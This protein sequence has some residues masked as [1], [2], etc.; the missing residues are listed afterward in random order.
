MRKVFLNRLSCLSYFLI[1]F[2]V[3]CL[4]AYSI[5][6]QEQITLSELFQET[7]ENV[8]LEKVSGEQFL[9][10]TEN[11]K[12]TGYA[13]STRA[14]TGSVG[15]SGKPLDIYVA[16]GLD[17]MIK[18]AK[19]IS[20]NEPIL[21]IGVSDRDLQNLVNNII[22][23]NVK[24]GTKET[25]KANRLEVDHITGATI[26][27]LVIKDSILRSAR[28]VARKTGI[29]GEKGQ[30]RIDR[31]TYQVKTWEELISSNLVQNRKILRS[32]LAQKVQETSE[33]GS[34]LIN[35]LHLALLTSPM[36]GQNLLGQQQ[37]ERLMA[38]TPI[39]DSLIFI[40][41]NGAYSFKG[42]A[43]RRSGT[44]DRIE[45]IQGSRTI[46]LKKEHYQNL[47]KLALK[48]APEF[49]EAGIFR[50]PEASGFNPVKPWS[51]NFLIPHDKANGETVRLAMKIN[52]VLPDQMI[53]STKS[54]TAP[55]KE[56][57]LWED[58]WAERNQEIAILVTMFLVLVCI[59]L[60]QDELAK[61]VKLYRITRLTFLLIT[62]VFLGLYAG[63]QLSVVNLI[64]FSQSLL[65]NFKWENF[66]LDP[67]I[68]MLWSFVA[69][70][71]LFWGRGVF[72]GWLCPFGALQELINAGAKR[73]GIKQ[74]KVPWSLHERLWPIKYIA[75][76]LIL[77]ISLKSVNEAYQYAEIE[78]FKTVI[79]LKF[80][81]EWQ[82][83]LYALILLVMGLF[84]ERFYC[85]YLCPLGAA[86]AIPAKLRLFEWLNR[87]PQCGRECRLCEDKCTVQ[88]INPIGQINPNECIYCLKC[89]ANYYDPNTC[90]VLKRRAARR[91][92][93]GNN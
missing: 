18:Q 63:A 73:L 68:F 15:Y 21:V 32:D 25:V 3:N 87:R 78:P 92:N 70:A 89:Q 11:G 30:A 28:A 14:I 34:D 80:L 12:P 6:A 52:Y 17:G 48:D 38:A 66:L 26:S 8:R 24:T 81:R 91:G 84:I 53:I 90:I 76:L 47:E 41:G 60:F 61:R 54:S 75:F 16:L 57:E 22:G 55:T 20:H 13:F 71:L 19:L 45:I 64:A 10:I 31:E 42:T 83:V 39:N 9:K 44:F 79:I 1:I 40:A 51:I 36:I 69:L 4:A 49:R 93:T 2:F 72:C 67:L 56:R 86:L 7:K 23:L 62:L 74:I 82:F 37:Y 77:G 27:S 59:L 50:I 58:I 88:A 46:K 85:R 33:S 29:I 65:G 35:N 43:Y 5:Q